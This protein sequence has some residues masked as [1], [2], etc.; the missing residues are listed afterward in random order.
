MRTAELFA[1]DVG[2]ELTT[3]CE[4]QV[5]G[6]W[7]IPAEL[8][9]LA[10]AGGA[11]DIS[12]GRR[13][14]GFA[15][16]WSGAPLAVDNLRLLQAALDAGRAD[17]ERHRA[18]IGMESSGTQ[19]LLWAAGLRGATLWVRVF[20]GR[21]RLTFASRHGSSPKLASAGA[22]GGENHVEIR[23][24]CAGLDVD[25]A[26]RWLRSAV[27]FAPQAV[28]VEGRP[29]PRG[30]PGGLYR[31]HL[32]EPVPCEL[33]VTRDG[34][35]PL[36][37]LLRDGVVSARATIPGYPAFQAAVELGGVVSAHASAADLRRA[38]DPHLNRLIDRAVWMMLQVAPRLPEAAEE[39]RR[40]LGTLVL[41]AADR[42]LRT[43]E[44]R[45][46]PVVSLAGSGVR[47]VSLDD[48]AEL[49]HRR[50]PVLLALE[51]EDETEDFL[52]DP[53]T[54]LLVSQEERSLLASL[55]AVRFQAPVRRREG[56]LRR[57]LVR[58]RRAT[59]LATQW[60][61]GLFRSGPLPES[62]LSAQERRLVAATRLAVA[63]ERIHL[64][65]GGGAVRRSR[66]GVLVPRESPAV[67][68][69]ALLVS[70]DLG[71]LYPVL[72]GMR[73]DEPPPSEVRERWRRM[74]LSV[75]EG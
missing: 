29:A 40:R 7:Q 52:L 45:K 13:R 4:A 30:F 39:D 73:P 61:R 48:L 11:N 47:L 38:V 23:W 2:S 67:A 26:V 24:S 41:R 53:D 64:A 33:G 12:A 8:V 17:D 25:R 18:I 68:A 1:I 37:Y 14:R 31:L 32:E 50:G 28:T 22:S 57:W 65:A 35:D 62:A 43:E 72:L 60:G 36:L 66:H 27:R 75:D 70:H 46:A 16:T 63:N 3:L 49:A 10:L 5:R 74:V 20:D 42:G 6:S 21:N 44:A 56:T 55:L 59:R 15:L 51:P 58:L 71:W 54:T 9:R 69:G 19:A 34:D